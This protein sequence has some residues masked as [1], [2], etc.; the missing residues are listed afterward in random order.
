MK[1]LIVDDEPSIRDYLEE[2]FREMGHEV[3]SVSDG[4]DAIDYVREHDVNLAYVDVKMPGIDGFETFRRLREIDPKIGGVMISGNAV[5]KMMDTSI[6]SG[7][8]VCLKKPMSIAKLEEI[9]KAY[10]NIRTPLEFV[11]KKKQGVTEEEIAA[12]KILIADD[13]EGIRK[14]IQEVL[15]E[16]GFSNIDVV[17]DGQ[18]AIDSFNQKKHDTVILD[19][20]MPNV[21]GVDVLRHVKALSPDS[22]VIIISGAADKDSAIAAVKLGA[23]DYIEKPFEVDMLT[24]VVGKAVEKS[25]LNKLQE[26]Q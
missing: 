19:I 16:S 12:A 26:D 14:I 17:K 15:F 18:E 23:F 22:E 9:N 20:K 25:L 4:Y 11:H 21:Q 1:I 13:E 3:A 7:V 5:E 8:Y 24:H 10:E 6:Q 2:V